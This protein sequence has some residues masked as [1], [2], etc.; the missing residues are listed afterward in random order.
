MKRALMPLFLASIAAFPAALFPQQKLTATNLPDFLARYDTNFGPLEGVFNDLRNENLPLTDET[1]QPLARR[2]LADRLI[3]ITNLRQTA[4]QFAAKPDDLVLATTV[5]IRTEIL[6]DDLFDLSQVAYDNDREDLGNRLSTLQT[7]M[8]E[9]KELLADYLLA[10]AAEKQN[11]LQQLEKEV[12]DLQQ[13]L[14]EATKP[15]ASRARG[16]V[17]SRLLTVDRQTNVG[18]A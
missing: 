2:P 6:A 3:A 15:A 8:E 1:G 11:R 16:A 9:N 5:V 10:L 13:K 17:E 14:K 18:E 4:R 7:T 12:E